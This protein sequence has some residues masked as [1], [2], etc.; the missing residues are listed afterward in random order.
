MR[1]GGRGGG[2]VGKG[3]KW[4]GRGGGTR[5]WGGGK[6]RKKEDGGRGREGG[7]DVGE[8]RGMEEGRVGRDNRRLR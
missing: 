5:E 8:K 7:K 4:R 3:K 6:G 1:L 2:R